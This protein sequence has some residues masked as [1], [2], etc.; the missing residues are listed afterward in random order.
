MARKSNQQKNGVDRHASNHKKRSSDLG[1]A[2]PD[3]KGHGKA[4]EVKVFPGEEEI[5]NGNHPSSPLGRSAG[6]ANNSGDEHKCKQKP[7]KQF[8]KDKQEMNEN[9]IDPEEQPKP[10]GSDSGECNGN[11]EGPSV[12]EENGSTPHHDQGRNHR[13]SRLPSS[14]NELHIQNLLESIEFS[15]NVV[16]RN[17]RALALS[18]FKAANEWMERQRPLFSTLRTKIQNARV[19]AKTKF[20][21][22]YPIVLKWLINFG[23]IMLL[24]LMVW[25]DCALRGIDSFLRLGTASFFSVIWCSVFS[26]IAMAGMFKFIVVLS[27]AALIG[28]FVGFTIGILVVAISGT[29][30]LW[31]YGSFWTTVLVILLGGLAFALSRERIALLITTVYSVYCAWTYAG[32]L[33][34]IFALN[35]A[36]ISSDILIYF[37]KNN[38]NQQRRPNGPAEEAP[39]MQ[40]QPGFFNSENVHASSFETGPGFSADRSPGVPSTSGADSDI[41]SEDEVVRLL[42]CIDHYSVLGLSRYDNVDVSLLKREYRK[43]AMLVHPDKNMGNEKAVEAFKK[44][45]NAYEVLL[46]SAKQK[47][48]DDELRKEE[49]LNIFRRFKSTSLKNGEHGFFTPGMAHCEADGDD[50]LGDSRRIACKKCNNFH[51]WI[52]TRKSKNRARWCQDCKDFHQAKDGDGW[53]EQSSQPFFFGLLQKVDA[54]AAF[55][56]AD[57]KIYNATEWYICQGMR[58]PANTHK[59]SFHVNTSITSKHN[60]GKGPSSSGQRGGRIPTSVEECMTEEEFFEWFQNAVQSGVFDNTN[61]SSSNESPS[62]TKA[63]N[64]TESGGSNGGGGGGSNKRKKKGKKQW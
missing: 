18:S 28:V 4:S 45:Q 2:Q 1:G 23:S 13:K 6:K 52:L 59:P 32:W 35:L 36:F 39:G 49:L 61:A 53:V 29:V 62:S 22:A 37:L 56:C 20:E 46:D 16:L 51:L 50:P 15:D 26:V 21:Q 58:C 54:P 12:A 42:N 34:L 60:T 44:L 63:G 19:Y 5:P 27:L 64:S 14:L 10:L 33:G 48:Y 17:L 9:G 8:K 40:G 41:T 47:A 30:F 11:N 3:I 38:M 31:L 57:S 24:I 55:V 43:K 7:M 25:L